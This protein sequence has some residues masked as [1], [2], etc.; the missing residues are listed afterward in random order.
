MPLQNVVIRLG[1]H[2]TFKL[3]VERL[4]FMVRRDTTTVGSRKTEFRK[5]TFGTRRT[6]DQNKTI[7]IKQN[8]SSMLKRGLTSRTQGYIK[9][10]A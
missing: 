7:D 2:K 3:N 4:D 8:R 10:C 1:F 9:A 5:I 6:A